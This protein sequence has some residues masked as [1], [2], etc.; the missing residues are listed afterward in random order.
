[1]FAL[2]SPFTVRQIVT[3]GA[4]LLGLAGLMAAVGE[5][6]HRQITR[7]H[8]SD[9]RDDPGRWGLEDAQ[10][11]DLTTRDGVKLHSWVFRSAEAVASVIVLHGHGGNKHTVL[12]LAHML[13]PR[14]NVLLLD[15]RGHG[16]SAGD[17]TTIGREERL[18]VHAAVEYL[19]EA[20]MGPVGIYGMSMGGA[21]A[22][23]AAAEDRRIAAVVADSPYGRLRWA[24]SQVA[25]LRGYPGF[26]TPSVAWIGCFATALHVRNR[27][28]SFDPVEVV[29]Q[30]TPRPLF[31]MHGSE[32]DVIPVASAHALY[33]RAGEPKELW[34]Q[35]GLK[36][37]RALDECYDEFRQR[38]VDFYDRWLANTEHG[39]PASRR[40]M[41]G[42]AS[43]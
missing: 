25:R 4:T 16:D 6:G 23:L 22:I 31:L 10:E 21:T 18:D 15:H 7:S 29:D 13:Y 3:A 9:F 30:I 34:I 38:I 24:V 14:Y 42:T 27:M 2:E 36:H 17:R 12:P 11:I 37:C 39:T 20:G 43:A 1:M 32:D 8:R 40:A 33:E 5:F 28:R 41:N 35:E 19:L 26:I